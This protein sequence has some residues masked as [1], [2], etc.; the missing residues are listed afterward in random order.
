MHI[1]GWARYGSKCFPGL[2][3]Y[4]A[5]SRHQLGKRFLA[6]IICS[7]LLLAFLI[8]FANKSDQNIYDFLASEFR[9]KGHN[10]VFTVITPE[11]TI[12]EF[13]AMVGDDSHDPKT[14]DSQKTRISD[15]LSNWYHLAMQHEQNVTS[16]LHLMHG[17]LGCLG[18]YYTEENGNRKTATTL[19]DDGFFDQEVIGVVK[20]LG[21]IDEVRPSSQFD[22]KSDVELF[23]SPAVYSIRRLEIL[24]K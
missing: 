7:L 9:T 8:V 19:I 21:D 18:K 22:L 1:C 17:R 5:C 10:G 14:S 4:L 23:Q 12:G 3:P 16:T 13:K 6:S 15:C 11:Y 20:A 2:H 24:C